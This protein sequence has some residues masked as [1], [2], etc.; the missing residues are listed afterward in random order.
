MAISAG[1]PHGDWPRLGCSIR[2]DL[3]SPHAECFRVK[4]AKFCHTWEGVAHFRLDPEFRF[5]VISAPISPGPVARSPNPVYAGVHHTGALPEHIYRHPREPATRAVVRGCGQGVRSGG[6]GRV[7]GEG[8]CLPH[9]HTGSR[10][11]NS[12]RPVPAPSWRPTPGKEVGLLACPSS[13][14]KARPPWTAWHCARAPHPTPIPSHLRGTCRTPIPP[15]PWVSRPPPRAD[16]A[17]SPALS[18]S[19]ISP[20]GKQG[21]LGIPLIPRRLW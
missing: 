5:F 10:S 7:C 21:S 16:G 19:N 20:G 4:P 17:Q 6:A 12:R 1:N 13:C 9:P 15:S 2:A 18:G 11:P 8:V 14:F 3:N